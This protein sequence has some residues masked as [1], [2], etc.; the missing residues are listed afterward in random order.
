[1]DHCEN[2][3]ATYYFMCRPTSTA[4]LYALNVL[5]HSP[6]VHNSMPAGIIHPHCMH[7]TET[8]DLKLP[9]PEAVHFLS[10]NIL[11]KKDL[12]PAQLTMQALLRSRLLLPCVWIEPSWL[13]ALCAP[14][15][16]SSICCSTPL[17]SPWFIAPS[18]SRVNT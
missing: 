6:T 14:A 16:S 15:L 18:K 4:L 3:H 7:R 12:N 1:M 10:I 11:I 9:R 5:S 8:K 13:P 17:A 2:A